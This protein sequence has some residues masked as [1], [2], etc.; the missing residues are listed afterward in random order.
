MKMQHAQIYGLGL[1][2]LA[3]FLWSASKVILKFSLLGLP[4]YTLLAGINIAASLSLWIYYLIKKPALNFY[5]GDKKGQILAL[6]AVVGYL[7]APLFSAIGLQ[8]VSV[9]TAGL[10]AALSSMM[11]V[12]LGTFLLKEKPNWH[13]LL[14]GIIVIIGTYMFLSTKL[15][16]ASSFGVIMTALA[17]MAFAL[18]VVLTRYAM[19]EVEHAPLLQAL[20][21]NNLA[22]IFM[23]PVALVTDYQV[24]HFQ[25][26]TLLAM[27]VLGLIFAFA[28]VIWSA[29]LEYMKAFEASVL[30]ATI[31][32]QS[33]V[34][35]IVFLGEI[36]TL[37]AWW[38]I[39]LV[40]VGVL[41]ADS[42]IFRSITALW[43]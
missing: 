22:A 23:I 17:E 18:T 8:Y 21:G 41:L 9:A 36:L 38:G 30:Q 39:G 33:G 42:K 5:F 12:I 2:F 20:V 25:P 1:A 43:R 19:N 13:F 31:V 10:F 7:A 16:A 40:L 27:G 6:I 29:A 26:I 3:T 24:A 37:K 14:G 11:V 28:G 15:F 4:P 35:S 32:A 34:L